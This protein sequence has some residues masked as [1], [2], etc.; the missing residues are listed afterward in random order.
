M[1]YRHAGCNVNRLADN[2]QPLPTEPN[3]ENVHQLLVFYRHLSP[4][5]V[6]HP[7]L[8]VPVSY[9]HPVSHCPSCDLL[10]LKYAKII[11]DK[12]TIHLCVRDIGNTFLLTDN[13]VDLKTRTEEKKIEN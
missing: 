5:S 11:I 4:H 9:I 2:M 3:R 12:I 1:D 10:I 6:T 8:F 7:P 13:G